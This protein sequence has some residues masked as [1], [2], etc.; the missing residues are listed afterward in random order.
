V[1]DVSPG[2]SAGQPVEDHHLFD[3]PTRVWILRVAKVLVWIIYLF[4]LVAMVLLL[5]AFFLR[6]FGANPE[7]GFAEWIYRSVDEIMEPFRGIFPTEQLSDRSVLDFSLLF[8]VIIYAIFAIVAHGIVSWISYR[9]SRLERPPAPPQPQP[10]YIVTAPAAYGTPVATT[11]VTV[12][13]PG[14]PAELQP[15]MPPPPAP[16]APPPGQPAVAPPAES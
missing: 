12:A 6:L 15:Q 5:I 9:L 4:V 16:P 2:A 3:K 1:T 11:T 7:S 14:V 10:Q 13:S 8:A